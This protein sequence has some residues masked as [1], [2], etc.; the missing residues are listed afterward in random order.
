MMI[1][2]R[3]GRLL[4]E[5]QLV[6]EDQIQ[7]ALQVQR[8]NGSRLGSIL[9][10]MGAISEATLLEF[11]SQQYGVPPIDLSCCKIESEVLNLVPIELAQQLMIVPVRQFHSRLALAMIDPSNI[12]VIDEMKFRTG[13]T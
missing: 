5:A 3:M 2:E 8:S 10:E 11:L 7:E 1:R 9:V 13:L 4:M 6:S 12:A